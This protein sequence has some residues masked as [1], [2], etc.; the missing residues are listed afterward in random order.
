MKFNYELVRKLLEFTENIQFNTTQESKF[1]KIENYTNDEISYHVKKL[2]EA[3]YIN[4][5]KSDMRENLYYVRELTLIGHEFLDSIRSDEIWN[6]VKSQIKALDTVPLS[7][8]P[9]LAQEHIKK[10]LGLK[11]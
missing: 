8:I 7:M 3:N 4:G 5:Y 11:E 10:K 2:L 9:V 6:S 1:I